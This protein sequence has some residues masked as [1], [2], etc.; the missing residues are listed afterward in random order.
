MSWVWVG[1]WPEGQGHWGAVIQALSA[2]S[3]AREG[4]QRLSHVMGFASSLRSTGLLSALRN[5]GLFSLSVPSLPAFT[6]DFS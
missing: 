5:E 6:V 2:H 4:T 1:L 3:K